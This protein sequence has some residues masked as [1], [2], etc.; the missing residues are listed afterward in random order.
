[1]AAVRGTEKTYWKG[2]NVFMKNRYNLSSKSFITRANMFFSDLFN[3]TCDCIWLVDKKTKLIVY[4]NYACERCY[5]Y[6]QED[7]IGMPV[8]EINVL[9]TMAIH[10]EMRRIDKSLT[11]SNSF[12]A[13]HLLRNEEQIDV[14]V[15]SKLT[16]VNGREYYLSRITD[17]T[18]QIRLHNDL[19]LRSLVLERNEACLQNDI[20]YRM[21]L[22]KFRG[23]N[24]GLISVSLPSVEKMRENLGADYFYQLENKLQQLLYMLVHKFGYIIHIEEGRF[25][26]VL[27]NAGLEATRQIKDSI[28][29]TA[30]GIYLEY[31][32]QIFSCLLDVKMAVGILD[33]QYKISDIIKEV[34]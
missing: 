25:L 33:N 32:K 27:P 8:S 30:E 13:V 14:Q 26:L 6:T 3:A 22:D 16:T 19:R 18:E 9:G 2:V 12:E 4:A 17:I 7:F 20:A 34:I 11:Q 21:L 24:I 10:R 23:C 5:G 15:L 31:K 1:M 28:E 29:K